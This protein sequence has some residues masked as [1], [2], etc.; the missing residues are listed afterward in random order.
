[1]RVCGEQLSGEVLQGSASWTEVPPTDWT[2]HFE[3]DHRMETVLKLNSSCF[4]QPLHWSDE[5]E[6]TEEPTLPPVRKEKKQEEIVSG[7]GV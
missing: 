6:L 1:M 5:S 3:N 4:L 2:S 7:S